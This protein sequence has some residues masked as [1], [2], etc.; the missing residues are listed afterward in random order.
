MQSYFLTICPVILY[1]V[2]FNKMGMQ[3]GAESITKDKKGKTPEHKS[4][5]K[6]QIIPR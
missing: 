5:K 4:K 2:Y 6:K 3:A 1:V